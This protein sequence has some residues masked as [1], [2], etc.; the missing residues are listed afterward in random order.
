MLALH[1]SKWSP[2]VLDSEGHKRTVT[3][4]YQRFQ[5][6]VKSDIANLVTNYA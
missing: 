3:R 5:G 6:P 4:S 2:Q 1:R